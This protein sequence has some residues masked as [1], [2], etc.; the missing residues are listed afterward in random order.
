M[1]PQG[2]P[3][4]M[5]TVHL[6][7]D[8]AAAAALDQAEQAAQARQAGGN[9]AQWLKIPGPQGQT[10]WDSSV[11]VGFEGYADVFICPPWDATARIPFVEKVTHWYMSSANP[12]GKMLGCTDDDNT[13]LFCQARKLAL[14]SLDP[15]IQKAAKDWGRKRRQHLYNVIDLTN[16]PSHYGQ[17]GIMR[18]FLFGAGPNCQSSLKRMFDTRGGINNFCNP[19]NGRPVRITKKKTGPENINVEWGA[20][21]LDPM[22]IDR[23]FWGALSNLWNLREQSTVASQS[24]C[25]DAIRELNWPVPGGQAPNSY[26]PDPA[27]P[28]GTP[29]GGQQGMPPAAP[30]GAVYTPPQG[31]LPPPPQGMMTQGQ[32]VPPPP[33]AGVNQGTPP[34]MNPPPVSSAPPPPPG[35]YGGGAGDPPF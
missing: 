7:D 16:P 34:P 15:A 12:K 14:A 22:A 18:S 5:P 10:K 13:C 23:Y 6:A 28:Y 32:G 33:P 30:Q 21:D 4:Q 31:S 19:Q 35:Q 29:Y 1:S 3:N 20:I 8:Q 2:D 27:P 24:D 25:L 17:D 11:P 9:F 26:N